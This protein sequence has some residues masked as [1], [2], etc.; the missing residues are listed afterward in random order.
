MIFSP[1]DAEKILTGKKTQT[2]RLVKNGEKCFD[3]ITVSATWVHKIMGASPT[4]HRTWAPYYGK[5]QVGRTYAVQPG[6]GKKAI[7][8]FRLL[9]IRR[10][11]LQDISHNDALAEGFSIE[12]P[13]N[14]YGTGSVV[15]DA[16]AE[17]WDSINTEPCGRWKDNP[18]VW[19]LE[20]EMVHGGAE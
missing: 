4:D 8:R 17:F 15:R 5:W 9:D 6:R 16:F 18:E 11:Y 19:V 3:G 7:G 1:L 2:R 13:L 20:F 10:E 14:N 12:H